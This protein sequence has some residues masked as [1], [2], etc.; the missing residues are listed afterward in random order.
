MRITLFVFRL[1]IAL[2]LVE[3]Y[4]PFYWMNKQLNMRLVMTLMLHSYK[5][6]DERSECNLI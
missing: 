1:F 3:L 5:Y 6:Y 4:A 2:R